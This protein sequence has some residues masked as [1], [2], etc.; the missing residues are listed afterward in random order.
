MASIDARLAALEAVHPIDPLIVFVRSF[1]GRLGDPIELVDVSSGRAWLRLEVESAAGFRRR[2]SDEAA[3]AATAR[4]IVLAERNGA[5]V[6]SMVAKDD[7][8]AS[9]GGTP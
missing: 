8:A 7:G 9:R 4:C 6:A 5:E 1:V 2:A 3:G